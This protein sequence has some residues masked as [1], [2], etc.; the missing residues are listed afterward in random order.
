[1]QAR[2]DLGQTFWR[3]QLP[4]RWLATLVVVKPG[5]RASTD[6]IAVNNYVHL[7]RTVATP[8]KKVTF[9]N[10]FQP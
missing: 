8:L 9:E 3:V 6:D 4:L 1:M 2:G 10:V 7:V 5:R